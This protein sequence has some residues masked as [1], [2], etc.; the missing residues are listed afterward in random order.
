[1][2]NSLFLILIVFGQFRSSGQ[3]NNFTS[4]IDVMQLDTSIFTSGNNIISRDAHYSGDHKLH[5][6][7]TK[8]PF[9]VSTTSTTD[10]ICGVNVI[11]VLK[12]QR[13][14]LGS[15]PLGLKGQIAADVNRSNTVNS[16]DIVELRKLVLGAYTQFPLVNSWETFHSNMLPNQTLQSYNPWNSSNQIYTASSL[17]LPSTLE[18]TGIKMGD[19]DF[20]CAACPKPVQL[21]S[22]QA[23]FRKNSKQELQVQYGSSEPIIALQQAFMLHGTRLDEVEIIPNQEIGLQISDFHLDYTTNQIRMIW[24]NPQMDAPLQADEI[25]FLV[26]SKQ[27]LNEGILQLSLVPNYQQLAANQQDELFRVQENQE[28]DKLAAIIC[29]FYPNLVQTHTVLRL[30]SELQGEVQ[31]DISHASGLDTKHLRWQHQGGVSDIPIDLQSGLFGTY[32]CQV[33]IGETIV[34]MK[35]QKI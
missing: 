5:T 32:L 21:P 35:L 16:N 18:F 1:M 3:K 27:D 26:R 34:R 8:L 13:H 17:P 11:D 31:I 2:Q 29:Q 14:I 4:L 23:V 7:T 20:T 9:E 33:K 25:L 12:V 22:V 10:P 24:T 28:S 15:A 30:Q 19:V 6:D